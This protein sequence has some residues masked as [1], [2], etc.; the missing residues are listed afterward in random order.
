MRGWAAL[1]GPAPGRGG[2]AG[3]GQCL[4]SGLELGRSSLA[5]AEGVR[6]ERRGVGSREG[7][8]ASN[9]GEEEGAR[10]LRALAEALVEPTPG[11]EER[12]RAGGGGSP[13]MGAEWTALEVA[14]I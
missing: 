12:R 13:P 11:R 8:G 3:R 4:Q 5:E 7:S 1:E 2:D 9:T 14:G 6:S 10:S